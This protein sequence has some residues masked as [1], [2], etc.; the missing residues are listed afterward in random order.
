MQNA[1][2]NIQHGTWKAQLCLV[3]LVI[4][5][6]VLDIGYFRKDI[7]KKWLSPI[8]EQPLTKELLT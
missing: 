8:K 4:P 7:N 3:Q 2:W 6:S 1:K 5:C